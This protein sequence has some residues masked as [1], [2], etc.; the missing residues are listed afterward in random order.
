MKKTRLFC[1]RLI[2]ILLAILYFLAL[3]TLYDHI[4]Y[5]QSSGEGIGIIYTAILFGPLALF[6]ALIRVW[7]LKPVLIKQQFLD[8]L[9]F[10]LPVLLFFTCFA[11]KLWLGLILSIIAVLVTAYDLIWAVFKRTAT[12]QLENKEK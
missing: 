2:L 9:H 10:V 12:S 4:G 8:I 7:L 11:E 5:D 6:L 1:Y 3:S